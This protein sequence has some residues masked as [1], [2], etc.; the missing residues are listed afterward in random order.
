MKP[1][2]DLALVPAYACTECHKLHNKKDG[3]MKCCTC[4]GCGHKFPGCEPA[5]GETKCGH[6]IY[7][8]H[9]Q[10]YRTLV[11]NAVQNLREAEKNL[12][13]FLKTKRKPEGSAARERSTL[14]DQMR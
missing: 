7:P 4:K 9:E 10:Y 1:S 8:E 6:C 13:A 5:L 3:A 14:R 11:D 2:K 12:N